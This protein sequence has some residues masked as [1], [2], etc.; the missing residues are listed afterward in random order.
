MRAFWIPSFLLTFAVIGIICLA[1]APCRADSIVDVQMGTSLPPFSAP[2]CEGIVGNVEWDTTTDQVLSATSSGVGPMG[3]FSFI[4][5]VKSTSLPLSSYSGY[6]FEFGDSVG[7]VA[8][9]TP[10]GFPLGGH[11]PSPG[12]YGG[13]VWVT[14]GSL[15]DT[16]ESDGFYGTYALQA[17]L[18]VT[19]ATSVAVPD[20][21]SFL[22]LTL[23]AFGA[24]G[25][26][27]LWRRKESSATYR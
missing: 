7:D 27:W 6:F 3:N 4:G 13:G 17:Q 25:F 19:Q 14:C 23:T 20:G 10:L 26:G 16:C 9:I 8:A 15:T 5:L 12:F 24:V 1:D 2:C 21:T 11:F 18:T 22:S